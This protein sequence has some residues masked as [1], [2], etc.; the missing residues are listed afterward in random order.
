MTKI[1]V[2]EDE[3]LYRENIQDLLEAE[4]FDAI[5][6]ENGLLG[7]Q[8]AQSEIPDLI[9]CDLMM[10]ELDGYG[11]LKALRQNPTTAAIPLIFLTAKADR[12]DFRVGMVLGADDYIT[13]PFTRGELLEAIAARLA[14]QKSITQ[15]LT[16]ALKQATERLDHL[17]HHDSATNLP[18]RLLLRERFNQI[19]SNRQSENQCQEESLSSAQNPL[20]LK[21]IPIL[22]VALDRFNSINDGLENQDR[23]RLIKEITDRITACLSTQDMVAR[24]NADRFAIVPATLSQKQTIASVAQAVLSSIAQPISLDSSQISIAASIGI[25]FYPNDGIELNQLIKKAAAAM[26]YTQKL[27]GNHYQF[28]TTA[29]DVNSSSGLALESSLRRAIEK[30]E[31]EVYYQPIVNLQ[32]S[33][34]IGAEALVRWFHPTRGMISPAEFIPVAEE[35]GS[36][37][38]IGEWVLQTAC[39]QAQKWIAAGFSRFQVSV[40]LSARQFSQ[41]HLSQRI[42]EI[43]ETT[44]LNPE[45][46]SLELTESILVENA[47]VA[48]ATLNKLKHLGIH[49]AI[50]DFGTGYA[51]LS[52]LKQFPF[53]TLK[54]DRSF[55]QDVTSDTQN[56]AIMTAVIQ[57]A[58]NFNL[59]TVAEGVET[60]AELTFLSQQKCDA[61]QGYIFSRP[62]PAWE[63]EKLLI[64]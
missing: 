14:R 43:L 33:Q 57:L 29:L 12:A 37:V 28:Y 32:T 23:N 8:L 4:E 17:L 61:M 38:P 40:N 2:I 36:I 10:P 18:N 51:S 34:I 58:H 49:I 41:Q 25:T 11:V 20:E 30:E 59:K 53:D 13:K 50:D 45:N 9:L 1:L 3:K 42:V 60:Q 39:A 7:V 54:I 21:P 35:T 26:F 64:G 19:I 44:G 55:L 46:L 5:S 62:L 27:G 52:Y 24:L 48:I 16:Q 22:L 47:E 56:T 6:A 15:P 63:F 31:F